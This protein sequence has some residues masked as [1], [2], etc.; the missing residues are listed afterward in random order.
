MAG[1]AAEGEVR[2]EL[3]DLVHGHVVAALSGVGESGGQ[4]HRR[5]DG[6]RA[7]DAVTQPGAL[8]ERRR[9][10]GSAA[11]EH[12]AG[13]GRAACLPDRRRCTDTPAVVPLA[14]ASTRQPTTRRAPARERP[15]EVGAGHALA[16][17]RSH[18]VRGGRSSTAGS[19]CS[20]SRADRR[21]GAAP[22]SPATARPGA[23]RRTARASTSSAIA[24]ISSGRGR[25]CGRSVR[26]RSSSSPGGRR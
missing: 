13:S 25:R 17:P 1:R 2:G 14:G 16:L 24:S 18:R 22:R 3:L 12:V 23:D 4:L 21:R 10:D 8:Q 5:V 6:E 15:G 7:A 9:L 20:A 26:Q 11:D 19:R